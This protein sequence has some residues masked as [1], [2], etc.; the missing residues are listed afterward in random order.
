MIACLRWYSAEQLLRRCLRSVTALNAALYLVAYAAYRLRFEKSDT[1]A[2]GPPAVIRES[3]LSEFYIDSYLSSMDRA[4]RPV[5]IPQ[6]IVP[7]IIDCT[8]RFWDPY[9]SSKR[10]MAMSKA[11]LRNANVKRKLEPILFFHAAIIRFRLEKDLRANHLLTNLIALSMY[12][13]LIEGRKV[14]LFRG[15]PRLLINEL[16]NQF[17][18]D[19]GHYEQSP[20]YHLELLYSLGELFAGITDKQEQKAFTKAETHILFSTLRRAYDFFNRISAG[21]LY[22]PRFNDSID[23]FALPLSF[24]FNHI[25]KNLNI[26]SQVGRKLGVSV[27]PQSGFVKV[28]LPKFS[29]IIRFGRVTAYNQPGHSCSDLL[30][31]NIFDDSGRMLIGNTGFNRY[32]TGR[33]RAYDKSS[34]SNSTVSILGQSSLEY[35][36]SFRLGA[37]SEAKLIS[38]FFTSSFDQICFK[39]ALSWRNSGISIYRTIRINNKSVIEVVDEVDSKSAEPITAYYHLDE[40]LCSLEEGPI[41]FKVIEGKVVK[42]FVCNWYL[43]AEKRGRQRSMH[44]K[45]RRQIKTRLIFRDL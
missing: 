42:N 24:S 40:S 29:I 14:R 31:L 23:Q 38:S 36:G 22:M 32:R 20:M 6:N 25:R 43:T 5:D 35:L 12:L 10:L 16:K 28:C 13:V 41:E 17:L 45:N 26:S 44:I 33:R 37:A 15:I 7:L 19:G 3:S 8:S 11:C 1:S 34:R 4:T 2:F 27:F 21:G 39:F 9:P 30:G 18:E